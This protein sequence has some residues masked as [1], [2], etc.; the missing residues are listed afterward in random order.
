MTGNATGYDGRAGAQYAGQA[1]S[2]GGG[3]VAQPYL[4]VIYSSRFD[5]VSRANLAESNLS[6]SVRIVGSSIAGSEFR[7]NTDNF[8]HN[9][10]ALLSTQVLPARP[11]AVSFPDHAF[12]VVWAELGQG[13]EAGSVAD[14]SWNIM[15]RF[16]GANGVPLGDEILVNAQ[17]GDPATGYTLATEF[18]A[19]ALPGNR[20]GVVFNSHT[21]GSGS[22][23]TTSD[24]RLA[25][26]NRATGGVTTQVLADGPGS[27]YVLHD[28]TTGAEVTADGSL[29]V[30]YY[31]SSLGIVLA[32]FVDADPLA[33]T[34]GTGAAGADAPVLGARGDWFDAEA[35]DDSLAGRAGDDRLYGGAGRDSLRGGDGN[36]LLSGGTGDDMLRGGGGNDTML[37]GL[38]ADNMA[39]GAGLDAFRYA[40]AAEG[41][42]Q[43]RN[44]IPGED[45]IEVSAS[46][47]GGGLA[48]GVL[49]AAAFAAN[50][51]GLAD[52]PAGTGQFIWQGGSTQVL[53]WDADGA[54]G[55]AAVRIAR[56]PGLGALGAGDIVVIA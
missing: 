14:D 13:T 25:V 1:A 6:V 41:G 18:L 10:S 42:D 46:G 3:L 45:V 16:F 7:V 49:A 4:D 52:A 2:V 17:P 27:Q 9:L 8:N 20:L 35:G 56:L 53:W 30:R 43:I 50:A 38:G 40:S 51:T 31:D 23:F 48:E 34:V 12:A 39:G 47:F 37:G 21:V 29:L 44:F 26:V 28:L 22:E 54:G 5:P 33:A 19:V 55:A 32:R 15:A 36:D 24:L 11:E